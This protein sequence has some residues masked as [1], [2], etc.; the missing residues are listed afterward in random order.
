MNDNTDELER[1]QQLTLALLT[2]GFDP[3]INKP[4]LLMGAIPESFPVQIPL[5]DQS[6]VL[7]TLLRSDTSAEIIVQ[8]DLTGDAVQAYYEGAL[9]ALG[10]KEAEQQMPRHGGFM[11]QSMNIFVRWHAVFCHAESGA[12]LTLQIQQA[13]MTPLKVRLDLNLDREMNPCAQQHRM[14]REQMRH[15]SPFDVFPPL[16]PPTGAKQRGGGGGSSGID[17]AHTTAN[18]VTDLDI[19]ALAS[20]YAKQLSAA[21]WTAVASGVD[22]PLAWHTWNF[23]NEEQEPWHGLLLIE[24]IPNKTNEYFLMLRGS[25]KRPDNEPALGGMYFVG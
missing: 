5:P 10:W 25:Y 6:I 22:G 11:H 20:H 4:R 17:D 15:R 19:A 16:I 18:L 21:N 14:R 13:D 24:Q 1:L 23:I 9:P 2:N 8:S 7:G 12:G 3:R